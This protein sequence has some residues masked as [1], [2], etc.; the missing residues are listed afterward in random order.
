M[1]HIRVW[2]LQGQ[3]NG[4][5]VIVGRLVLEGYC[6]RVR[7]MPEGLELEISLS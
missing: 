5:R 7:V 3:S 4:V 6:Y 1:I 2:E